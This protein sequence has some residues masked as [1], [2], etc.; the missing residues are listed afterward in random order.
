MAVNAA[1]HLLAT[2]DSNL[3]PKS[4]DADKKKETLETMGNKKESIIKHVE[5]FG[6]KKEDEIISP[7]R[8]GSVKK[9]LKPSK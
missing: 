7:S 9:I 1:V 3:S 4:T 8:N 6:D 5:F 2:D